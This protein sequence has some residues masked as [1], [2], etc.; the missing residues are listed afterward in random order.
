MKW[1]EGRTGGRRRARA[2]AGGVRIRCLI[3]T[4]NCGF[5]FCHARVAAMGTP[6]C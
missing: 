2:E 4:G 3:D 6:S 5:I 1:L